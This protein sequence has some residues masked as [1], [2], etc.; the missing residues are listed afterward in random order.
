MSISTVHCSSGAHFHLIHRL[1]TC[2]CVCVCVCVRERESVCVRE[3]G[4]AVCF[5]EP[6][7]LRERRQHITSSRR[8]AEKQ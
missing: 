3:R 8:G 7:K 2:V 4:G 6:L 1:F 5:F